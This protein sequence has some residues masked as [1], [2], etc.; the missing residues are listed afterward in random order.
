MF[1][2]IFYLLLHLR[3]YHY[4]L[5]SDYRGRLLLKLYCDQ[6][7]LRRFSYPHLPLVAMLCLYGEV[8]GV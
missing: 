3:G 1:I 2:Q 8:S 7:W 6:L 4:S 5:R